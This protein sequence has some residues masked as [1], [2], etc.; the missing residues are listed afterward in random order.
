MNKVEQ[1]SERWGKDPARFLR[2]IGKGAILKKEK[3]KRN[4][5]SSILSPANKQKR[6]NT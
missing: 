5:T 3:E 4:A 6:D 1:L 2:C